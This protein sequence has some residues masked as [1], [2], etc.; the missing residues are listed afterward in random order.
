MLE[1]L[2]PYYNRLFIPLVKPLVKIGVHP[3]H[4]TLAGVALFGIAAWLTKTNEW[5]AALFLV[6]AGSLLDG[7]DGV[8]ARE[9]AKQSVFGGIL[10]SVC[11]RITEILL[12]LGVLGFLL[13][14]PLISF[15]KDALSINERAWGV[16]LCYTA[17]TMSLM[18]SYVKARCEGANIACGRGFLQR[19]ERI[20]LFCAG[21]CFGPHVMLWV[22]GAVSALGLYT[23]VERLTIAYRKTKA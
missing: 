15:S 8:L 6:I 1:G 18:V 21:L 5:K 10:D 2:K 11:D 17:I 9:A 20:I 23:V 22:L 13:S 16:I 14:T 12:L 19:P 4:C 7:L 3:N